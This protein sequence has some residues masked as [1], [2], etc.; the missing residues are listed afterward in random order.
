MAPIEVQVDGTIQAPQD[1]NQL[2]G[3]A[4]WIKFTYINFLTLSG[5]GTFDGQGAIAWSQNNCG[6]T[7]SCKKLSMVNTKLFNPFIYLFLLHFNQK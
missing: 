3:D 6:K 1:P 5:A 7:K 4:Q 2:N